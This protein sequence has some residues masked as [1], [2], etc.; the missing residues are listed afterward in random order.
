MSWSFV[1]SSEGERE[2]LI[3]VPREVRKA[4]TVKLMKT[5][6]RREK[7]R[8]RE[9]EMKIWTSSHETCIAL[10]AFRSGAMVFGVMVGFAGC[11]PLFRGHT[12]YIRLIKGDKSPG[13]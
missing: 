3:S 7:A 13:F 5:Q 12:I 9:P 1:V 4:V 8:M 2:S 6:K 10:R 11:L